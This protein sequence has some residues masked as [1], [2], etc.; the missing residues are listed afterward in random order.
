MSNL[1]VIDDDLTAGVILRRVLQK[2]RWVVY[3][4]ETVN[5]ALKILKNM[6]C[7]ER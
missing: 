6:K 4:A 5:K 2:T 3:Q 1:L 7:I